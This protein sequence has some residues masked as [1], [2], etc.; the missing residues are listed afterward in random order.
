MMVRVPAAASKPSSYPELLAVRVMVA[1]IGLCTG[2]GYA[3][4]ATCVTA[5]TLLVLT[6]LKQVERWMRPPEPT[7]RRRDRP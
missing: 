7:P 6:V 3:L 1:A 2:L 5:M 4:L